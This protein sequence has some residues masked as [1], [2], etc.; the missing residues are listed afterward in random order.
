[1]T[2]IWAGNNAGNNGSKVISSSSS[3]QKLWENFQFS[4][5]LEDPFGALPSATPSPGIQCMPA[6]GPFLPC[7]DLFD[8]WTLRCSVWIV[9]LLALLGNGCVVIVLIA[10]RGKMDVPRFLVCNLAMA[11]FCMGLYL[12]FLAIVDASSLGEFRKMAIH[13]QYSSGCQVA[14]FFGVLSS[15]L[16]V[17]TLA[18]IT[19]ERNYAITH[20]MH[21]NKRSAQLPLY[22]CILVPNYS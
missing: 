21:L 22:M 5:G 10:S 17:F 1:M 20:A 19:L 4:S 12:G 16:S 2:D 13:W 7:N 15:E 14:G 18:V 9:F 3:F 8:W 6:P 11:D